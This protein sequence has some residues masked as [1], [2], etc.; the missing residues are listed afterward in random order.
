MIYDRAMPRSDLGRLLSRLQ[1]EALLSRRMGVPA[2]ELHERMNEI[3][4]RRFLVGSMTL[5][6]ATGQGSLD[7]WVDDPFTHGAVETGER[8][9]AEIL[10]A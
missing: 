5:G 6:A 4:R 8:V 10:N 2:A 7:S 1:A 3:G 9:A